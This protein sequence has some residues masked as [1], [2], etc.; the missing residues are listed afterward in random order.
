MFQ[1][2]VV[3]DAADC[4][5]TSH[6]LEPNHSTN[7]LSSLT[8]FF[9]KKLCVKL[10]EFDSPNLSY[11]LRIFLS[12]QKEHKKKNPLNIQHDRLPHTLKSKLLHTRIRI[13]NSLHVQLQLLLQRQILV[14]LLTNNQIHMLWLN[15]LTRTTILAKQK[16]TTSKVLTTHKIFI[17]LLILLLR[18]LRW[19]L[20]Q[21]LFSGCCT[22]AI[23]IRRHVE[24][25]NQEEWNKQTNK[26]TLEP[27]LKS[28]W[29]FEIRDSMQNFDSDS[30]KRN[31][32]RRLR[33]VF[34]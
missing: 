20:R 16:G 23:G 2:Y 4:L 10:L 28:W 33:S 25:T 27:R 22:A 26:P 14:R 12:R 7:F 19:N 13:L 32:N 31:W 11:H 24:L 3:L 15:Y 5:L 1:K 21:S 17:F 29:L 9:T 6:I 34:V 30:A 8:R 18:V